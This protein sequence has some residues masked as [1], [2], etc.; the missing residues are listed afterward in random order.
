[1]HVLIGDNVSNTY[2]NGIVVE[3]Y[4]QRQE[5]CESGRFQH[6][7]NCKDQTSR[8]KEI[9]RI[10]HRYV[11]NNNTMCIVDEADTGSKYEA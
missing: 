11:T 1:M 9:E 3:W 8:L 7:L 5:I 10:L 2:I 4:M 6:C